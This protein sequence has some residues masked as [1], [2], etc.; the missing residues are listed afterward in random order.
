MGH[1]VA[2]DGHFIGTLA[3]SPALRR[4]LPCRALRVR[5]A[6]IGDRRM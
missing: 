6:A 1:F 3:S 4:D 5:Q 2:E